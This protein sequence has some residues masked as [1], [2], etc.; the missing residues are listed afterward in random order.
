METKSNS[1]SHTLANIRGKLVHRLCEILPRTP[2]QHTP[3]RLRHVDQAHAAVVHVVPWPNASRWKPF[4]PPPS[5]T[6]ASRQTSDAAKS[7]SCSYSVEDGGNLDPVCCYIR[8]ISLDDAPQSNAISYAWEDHDGPGTV[9]IN[10]DLVNLPKSAELAVRSLRAFRGPPVRRTHGGT[11]QVWLDAVCINQRDDAEKISQLQLMRT[12]Y[13][14]SE[15]LSSA[16]QNRRIH[17]ALPS[18]HQPLCSPLR[19]N[20]GYCC[21]T[22]THSRQHLSG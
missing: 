8:N 4:L 10:G 7:A 17:H 14:S 18:K 19:S 3:F 6:K 22:K 5:S 13:S 21:K 16:P 20:H 1:I 9:Y 11:S 12:I 2:R 15:L